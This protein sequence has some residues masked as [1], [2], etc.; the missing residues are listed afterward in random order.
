MP[1]ISPDDIVLHVELAVPIATCD[2]SGCRKHSLETAA[3]L[4]EPFGY[5][6]LCPEHH[7]VEHAA[8]LL[9]TDAARTS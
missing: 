2:V 8:K 6:A 5:V 3:L 4:V 9:G 1:K 7:D